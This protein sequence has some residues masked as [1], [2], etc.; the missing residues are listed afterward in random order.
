MH[1][2]LATIDTLGFFLTPK[3]GTLFS[4]ARAV[5][6]YLTF[7]RRAGCADIAAFK[8]LKIAILYFCM[9]RFWPSARAGRARYDRNVI[10]SI[11]MDK[12]CADSGRHADHIAKSSK[13]VISRT[14]GG[15]SAFSCKLPA[16]RMRT[17]SA[18]A[19]SAPSKSLAGLSAT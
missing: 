17:A 11:E 19:R 7:F 9:P 15:V 16:R 2:S 4:K 12:D 10:I 18:P 6:K 13:D 3:H 1:I 5:C 14:P 8:R